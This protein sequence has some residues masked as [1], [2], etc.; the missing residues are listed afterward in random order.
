MKKDCRMKQTLNEVYV[1]VD[2]ARKALNE[3]LRI[4]YVQ[5]ILAAVL[6]KLEREE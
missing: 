1:L 6:I 4:E 3:G 5:G 2:E